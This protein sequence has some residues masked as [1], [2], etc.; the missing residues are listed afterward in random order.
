MQLLRRN[1]W[2]NDDLH[3]ISALATVSDGISMK[4]AHS[5]HVSRLLVRLKHLIGLDRAIAFTVMGR[6]WQVMA[7]TVTVLLIARY[8][9]PSEQGYYYTFAS[10]LSL[11][12]VFELGFSFVVLQLTAHERAPLTFFPDG[13]I[14][15]NAIARSRVASVL[16]KSIRWYSVAALLMVVTV[17]PAGIHFFS[18]HHQSGTAVLWRGPWCVVAVAVAVTFQLNPVFSFWEGCGFIWHVARMRLGQAMLGSALAWTALATHH[19]LFAPAMV[20]VGQA[21]VGLI[22]LLTGQRRRLL[23][24]LLLH[25]VGEH[26]VG[27]WRE[28]WPFQWKIALSWLSGYFIFAIFN[29]LLFAYQGSVAAGRMGMSLTISG[30]VGVIAMAW[31]NTKASP[32]GNLVARNEINTLDRLFFRTLGQSVALCAAGAAVVFMG[33]LV[34]GPSY[35]KLAAR[36]LTPWAFGMLLLTT[37]VNQVIFS[38]ALYLRAHKREPFLVPSVTGA[39]TTLGMTW[40]MAKFWGANAVALGNF[41]STALIGLPWGTYIFISKRRQWHGPSVPLTNAV[42]VEKV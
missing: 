35:P 1:C 3:P 28:I 13:R 15:G 24:T 26:C 10:L 4:T 23:T 39:F 5:S 31:M 25:P 32:F 27:W 33:L 40:V 17:L 22:F 20:I 36:V 38:E 30:S 41:L 12:V 16:Q 19:G 2:I 29:P 6:F 7:G 34:V 42:C 18:S 8:L 21:T 14:E 37:L 9:T 11:Q